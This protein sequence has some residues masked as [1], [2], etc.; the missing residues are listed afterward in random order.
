[1]HEGEVLERLYEARETLSDDT[2]SYDYTNWRLCACGHIYTA[3]T[4]HVADRG[5]DVRA[6]AHETYQ[7]VI[8]TAARAIGWDGQGSPHR[9]EV[10]VAVMY[11]SH[12]AGILTEGGS[13]RAAAVRVVTRAIEKI[14][15]GQERARLDV[16]AQTRAIIDNAEPERVSV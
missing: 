11:V 8:M 14:E 3:S 7:E 1:M 2:H 13:S 9:T 6:P 5:T 15:Q 10:Q 4:G 16:L 12:Y